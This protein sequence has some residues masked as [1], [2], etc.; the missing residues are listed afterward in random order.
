MRKSG[1][2]LIM[3]ALIAG[4]VGCEFG[5]DVMCGLYLSSTT[6][7]SVATPGEG[8]FHYLMLEVVDLVA[9]ADEGYHFVNWSGDVSSIGDVHT[10]STNVTMYD[11]YNITANFEEIPTVQYELA[12]NSTEGGNVTTPGEGIFPYEEGTVV[13]L[14][15]EAN[16][17][18]QFVAWTGN[19]STVADIYAAATNITMNDNYSITANFGS[20]YGNYSDILESIITSQGEIDSYE[21]MN[22]IYPE[23]HGPVE[24]YTGAWPTPGELALFYWQDVEDQ[25]PYGSNTIDLNGANVQLGPL[26]RDGTLEIMNSSSTPATLTLAGTTYITG[27][28]LIG[29]I[30]KDLTLDL[31]GQTIF[32]ASDTAGVQKA[33]LIGGQVSIQGPGCIIA[34]GDIYSAPKQQVTTDPIFVLSVSGT[35]LLQPGGDL[36]GAVAG[37]IDVEVKSGEE[38]TITFPTDGFGSLNLNF[39]D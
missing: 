31:N 33:L 11:S 22:L 34:V 26:Y 9:V 36:Y 27:D 21:K 5:P 12:I 4:M 3:V 37:S 8:Q 19:V 10:P 1:T 23:G 30:G 13:D 17:D 32:V 25:T 35:I 29:I 38:P 39:P 16:E 20:A 6:G 7:G 2:L 18:Y 24:N 15:A 14:V 28:T